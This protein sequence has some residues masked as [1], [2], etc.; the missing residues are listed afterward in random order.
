MAIRLPPKLT[1]PDSHDFHP[2]LE[3]VR[4]CGDVESAVVIV[5]ESHVGCADAG[6]RLAG[7]LRQMKPPDGFTFGGI[8]LDAA[9]CAAARGVEVSPGIDAHSVDTVFDK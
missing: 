9:G 8:D 5:A 1:G 7:E 4:A 3:Q 6:A 2:N